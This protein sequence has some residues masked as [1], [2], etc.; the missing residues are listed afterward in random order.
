MTRRWCVH[1]DS[2]CDPF[3][4]LANVL[5]VDKNPYSDIKIVDFGFSKHFNNGSEMKTRLGTRD[6]IAPEVRLWSPSACITLPR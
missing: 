5:L 2:R 4:Q 6:Y 1:S 3:L